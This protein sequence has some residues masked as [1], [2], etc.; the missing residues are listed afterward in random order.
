MPICRNLAIPF[1]CLLLGHWGSAQAQPPHFGLGYLDGGQSANGRYVVTAALVKDAAKPKEPGQWQFAWNDTKEKQQLEGNLVGINNG[2]NYFAPVHAHIFVAPDGETFAVA[3]LRALTSNDKIA[4]EPN[5]DEYRKH[6]AFGDR[7]VI[8]RKN[9]EIVKR[10]H[11]NDFLTKE[12]WDVAWVIGRNVYWLKEFPGLKLGTTPRADYALYQISPDYT[13]IEILIG[14]YRDGK[15]KGR[16]VRIDCVKGRILD[17]DEVLNAAQ[18][19]VRP[20]AGPLLKPGEGNRYVPSLDPVRVEG[21]LTADP[22]K[23]DAK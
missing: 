17:N 22:K 2:G 15:A 23:T 20:F 18:L 1:V 3:N 19:P 6:P 8:Y 10:F 21:E 16:A 14:N 13:V 4:N 11:L 5:T 9:G 12:E 7:L